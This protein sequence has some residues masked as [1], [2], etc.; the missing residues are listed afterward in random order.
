MT[1]SNLY[2]YLCGARDSREIYLEA[3]P[4]F[5]TDS[6]EESVSSAE[7]HRSSVPRASLSCPD[8]ESLKPPRISIQGK[9]FEVSE[10]ETHRDQALVFARRV[11]R[12]LNAER[13]MRESKF[14]LIQSNSDIR[15][16]YTQPATKS[17]PESE[18][19]AIH[20]SKKSML[21]ITS[22]SQL[23]YSR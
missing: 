20:F 5:Q 9:L 2:R 4:L 15:Y 16:S 8:M 22:N 3:L 13:R 11:L 12:I 6:R 1:R 21:K 17:E 23:N 10:L 7:Q 14:D 19:D 18:P